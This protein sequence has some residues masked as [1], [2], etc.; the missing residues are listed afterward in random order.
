MKN[1]WLLDTSELCVAS[2]R[3]TV[4][5]LRVHRINQEPRITSKCL[6]QQ[7]STKFFE[8]LTSANLLRTTSKIDFSAVVRL[9]TGVSG[10]FLIIEKTYVDSFPTTVNVIMTTIYSASLFCIR[11]LWASIFTFAVE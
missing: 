3:E 7:I 9:R 5:I 11:L 10:I 4:Q 8:S 6:L 1:V 2:N